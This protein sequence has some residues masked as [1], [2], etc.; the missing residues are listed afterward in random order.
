MSE[1]NKAELNES[2]KPM[3]YM[4]LVLLTGLI[5]GIFWSF[6]G[7][8]A[9]VLNLTEIHPNVV[10]DPWAA[11]TWKEKW[12]G[13]IISIIIIGMI[14][15]GSALIYYVLLRRFP[16]IWVGILY[17]LGIFLLVFYGLN[18]IMP[19]ISPITELG[20]D[21]VITSICFYV[22]YG[23]FIGYTISYEYK[24]IQYKEKRASAAKS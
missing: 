12:I 14:S 16:S 20:R 21:T 2:N 13:T 5:G 23:V 18:P 17:G 8:L 4:T 9:Y 11:G 6:L 19:G 22:L 1:N 7:Y 10:L 24:E 15:I 3:S